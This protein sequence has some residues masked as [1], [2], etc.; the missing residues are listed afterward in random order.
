MS[1]TTALLDGVAA[2]ERDLPATG[3]IV[4]A[5]GKL[6]GTRATLQA[7]RTVEGRARTELDQAIAEASDRERRL[8]G[9]AAAH[10]IG[11]DATTVQL[12]RDAIDRFIRSGDRLV[13]ARR[14]R[15]SQH[16][17]TIQ[18]RTWYRRPPPER[19]VGDTLRRQKVGRGA[20]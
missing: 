9:T 19:L 4:G 8:H 11:A 10:S 17:Q 20:V 1:T 3:A 7:L 15:A 14:D 13:G 2:A 6:A 16:E 5:L 12:A 18:G